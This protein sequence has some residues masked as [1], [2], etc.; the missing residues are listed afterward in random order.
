MIERIWFHPPLAFARLGPSPIPCDNFSWAANDLHPRGTGKTV[1]RPEETLQLAPDGTVS[2]RIPEQAVFKD[3]TGF[4]PVCPFFEVHGSWVLDGASESGPITTGVLASNGLSLTDVRWQVEVAN[5]KAFHYTLA[6]GDRI[7]AS[8]DVA[9]DATGLHPLAGRSPADAPKPLVPADQ[10]VPLGWVQPARPDTTF[11]EL[12]LRFTPAA[13]AVYGP[14][15]LPLRSTEFELPPERLILNPAAAWA[16]FQLAGDSR[17][18][19]GGLFAGAS[20]TGVSLGL[21]D[22]VCDGIVRCTIA[23]DVTAAARIVVGPPDYA[24]DRR[25]FT[26]IADGLTD[27][28]GRGDVRDPGYVADEALTTREVRDLMERVIETMGNVNV[29]VQNDRAGFENEAIAAAQGLPSE[30]ARGQAFAVAEPLANVSLPLTELGRRH[31]R[32]FLSLEVFE[33]LLREQPDVIARVIR[34]PM[35]GDRYYDRRMPAMMRGSDR[36]PMHLT[37]RQFDL[38]QAWTSQLR[39]DTEEGT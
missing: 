2:T 9:G 5:L 39:R 34:E 25:P 37:R 22:D 35:T 29:D 8:V 31:H 27:R 32:R 24:P 19:P 38:L 4:R 11:P 30:A 15:D 1:V 3:G 28:V 18:N 16:G 23:G 17:T 14:T 21:M 20:D 10:H 6:P 36:Y 33:D 12:R 7:V 26:S 13:G